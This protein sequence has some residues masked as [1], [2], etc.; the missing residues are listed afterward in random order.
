MN[1]KKIRIDNQLLNAVKRLIAQARESEFILD[2]AVDEIENLLYGNLVRNLLSTL[3]DSNQK[4]DLYKEFGIDD[5]DVTKVKDSKYFKT[6]LGKD[7]LKVADKDEYT[8]FKRVISERISP[9]VSSFI[10]SFEEALQLKEC[11]KEIREIRKDTVTAD[12]IATKMADN[13]ERGFSS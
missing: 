8:R 9:K 7:V 6:L 13:I 3:L 11:E 1:N 12:E 10:E 5:K 2:I 4:E